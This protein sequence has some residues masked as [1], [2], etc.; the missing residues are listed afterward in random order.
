[1]TKNICTI[2]LLI[3]FFNTFSQ[4]E[5][6]KKYNTGEIS[7]KETKY[8]WEDKSIKGFREEKVEV[9]NKKGECI[10]EG[11]R[12]NYAGH[13]SVVL[14]YHNNGGVK[15]IETSEAPDAGI[16]WYRS[17][18]TIDEEGKIID[19]WEDSYN[20][21][22]TF[23]KTEPITYVNNCAVP[24]STKIIFYNKSKKKQ[25]VFLNP[26]NK[27]PNEIIQQVL[28]PNDSLVCKEIITSERFASPES[29]YQLLI[30]NNSSKKYI[31]IN[32]K[33]LPS[34]LEE[35]NKQHRIIKF[36]IL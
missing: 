35:P 25:E 17:K 18:Y 24:M 13:S 31:T 15:I 28:K 2:L 12:R 8:E 14:T 5:I 33:E 36:Y 21:Q 20:H 29:F 22:I 6:I 26:I 7:S 23:I 30:K 19:K 34:K 11:Y 16:Q 9:F 4:K 10:Y 3:V 1:M 27:N 32:F